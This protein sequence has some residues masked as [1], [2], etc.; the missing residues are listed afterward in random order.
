MV[1]RLIKTEADYEQA[2]SRIEALMD[3]EPGTPEADELELLATLVEMYEDVHYPVN[4]PDPIDAIR[5]RM[6]QAGLRQ[7][8][9]VPY[10]GSRSKVSEVL[11]RKRPLT[12]SMM[13]GLHRGLGIP[14]EVLL[15]ETG[16]EFPK[17][18]PDIQWD[19]FPVTEM[20][21]RGWIPGIK[22]FREKAEEL[23]R[24]FIDQAGGLDALPQPLLRQ[25]VQGRVNAKTDSHAVF[26]WC[27][28][29]VV[30]AN[31]YP[32]ETSFSKERLTKSVLRDIARLSYFQDG[33]LLAK[34]YLNKQGIH[35]F[36]V[37]HLPKTYLDG[38]AML[39]PN[40]RAIVGMTLRYDREDNFWFCLLHELA[41]L[42]R[43]LSPDC[44][45]IIDD[46]DLRKQEKTSPDSIEKEAD[47]L[48]SDALI[49]KKYQEELSTDMV[50]S[51]AK[52]L[53]LADKLKVSP[54]IVAG[55]VRFIRN[56]YSILKNIVGQGHIRHLFPEYRQESC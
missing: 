25:S 18:M 20:A 19:R 3:A 52:I 54:V 23:I 29:L 42:A 50:P 51:R 53:S 26:A 35:F 11:N 28:R 14:A 38:G 1:N 10:I 56:N 43:H 21:K 55:R 33:P 40:G 24:Y 48:A 4:M 37:P 34:E 44:R 47:A 27:L 31:E 6:E 32:L 41:H 30:L 22:G 13:R 46:M 5:F 9:L 17:S 49:P 16:A 39:L 8:D 12:L 15:Q 2:L 36:V 45:I 7:Q